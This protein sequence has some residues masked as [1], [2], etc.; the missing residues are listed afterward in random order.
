MFAPVDDQ[1]RIKSSIWVQAQ[2]R[3][4]DRAV[5]P[6]VV[7][8]RGDPDAGAILIKLDRGQNGFVVLTRGYSADGRQ[9][10]VLAT[11]DQPVTEADADAYLKRQTEF[12]PDIWIIAIE[13]AAGRYQPDGQAI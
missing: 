1:P 9:V 3:L 7:M 13:D 4:C 11:G 2:L 10:W 12:D 6:F 8:R 5:I